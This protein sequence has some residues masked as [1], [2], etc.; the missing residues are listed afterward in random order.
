M[1]CSA[2]NFQRIHLPTR[3]MTLLAAIIWL[4]PKSNWRQRRITITWLSQE[5]HVTS[6]M[7]TRLLYKSKLTLLSYKR[8]PCTN[9][10]LILKAKRQTSK[11]RLKRL[12]MNFLVK[13][14]FLNLRRLPW[15][16][17]TRHW[18]QRRLVFKVRCLI[19][20]EKETLAML[21]ILILR[22]TSW[23]YKV[24]W[25]HSKSFKLPWRPRLLT[26]RFR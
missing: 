25:L 9:R 8:H 16:E 2:D 26:F 7:N 6:T 13:S 23:S 18:R 11:H 12:P 10:S 20:Q 1:T 21:P 4:V 3:L 24:S 14:Q 17:P 19:S 5:S 15:L 22:K